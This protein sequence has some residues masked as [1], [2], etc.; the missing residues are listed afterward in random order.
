MLNTRHVLLALSLAFL[1][2]ASGLGVSVFTS[3]A[4][5]S[6]TYPASGAA[7]GMTITYS[8]SGVTLGPYEDEYMTRGDPVRYGPGG[9]KNNR[10][11]AVYFVPGSTLTVSG[12]FHRDNVGSWRAGAHGCVTYWA[13]P[14][15]LMIT[16][17]RQTI[18][19]LTGGL[20]Q[21]ILHGHHGTSPSVL[22]SLYPQMLLMLGLTLHDRDRAGGISKSRVR[23]SYYVY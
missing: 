8:V 9:G 5:I 14:R 20:V 19:L 7:F 4:D 21:L 18:K 15:K 1:I 22:A 23:Q 16:E 10:D 11:C 17:L 12:N 13:L 6:G 3:K 2:V